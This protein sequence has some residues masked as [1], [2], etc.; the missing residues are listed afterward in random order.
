MVIEKLEGGQTIQH[1][2]GHRG[3]VKD[4]VR[5]IFGVNVAPDKGHR[6]RN[7]KSEATGWR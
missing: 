3:A 1:G 4:P 7:W 2:G 6:R 5:E